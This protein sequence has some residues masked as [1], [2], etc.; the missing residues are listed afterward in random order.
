MLGASLSPA[1]LSLVL[2]PD[3]AEPL[4]PLVSAPYDPRSQSVSFVPI[5]YSGGLVAFASLFFVEVSKA[6]LSGRV[7]QLGYWALCAYQLVLGVDIMRTFALDWYGYLLYFVRLSNLTTEQPFPDPV[8][9]PP[10]FLSLAALIAAIG[11]CALTYREPALT[12]ATT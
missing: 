8:P 11:C 10:P 6:I 9:W 1:E 2:A 12:E 4:L 5:L 3:I 7:G